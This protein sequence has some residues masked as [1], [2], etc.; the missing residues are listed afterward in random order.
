MVSNPGLKGGSG[1]ETTETTVSYPELK[2]GSGFETTETTVSYPGL[3]GG[4][5]SRLL[6]PWSRTQG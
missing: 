1:F 6:K 4:L 3:K 2:G 5:G